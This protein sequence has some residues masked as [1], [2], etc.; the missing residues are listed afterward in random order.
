MQAMMEFVQRFKGIDFSKASQ[1]EAQRVTVIEA[2][3]AGA[4]FSQVQVI[5]D[6]VF[7]EIS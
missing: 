4:S 6:N 2:Q 3:K 7:T 1:V 5:M